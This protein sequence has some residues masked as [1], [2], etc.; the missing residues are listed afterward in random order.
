MTAEGVMKS[1]F[2]I[3]RAAR[4][5]SLFSRSIFILDV[6]AVVYEEKDVA[7]ADIFWI[8]LYI[9]CLIILSIMFT[10]FP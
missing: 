8:L 5:L 3:M 7:L 2:Q 9:G 6:K 1:A 4:F 10:M